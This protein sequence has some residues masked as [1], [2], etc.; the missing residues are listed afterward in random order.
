[1]VGTFDGLKMAYWDT[2]LAIPDWEHEIAPL[3]TVIQN[4]RTGIVHETGT[5]AWEV[6]IGYA[7]SNFDVVYKKG[8]E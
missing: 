6:A 2:S 1:M 4:K 5:A 7:S 8:E 3:S